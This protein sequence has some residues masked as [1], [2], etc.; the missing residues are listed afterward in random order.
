MTIEVVLAYGQAALLTTL[1]VAGPL[2]LSSLIVGTT[3]SVLQA[4]TQVQEVTLV[5]VPKIVAAF[6]V[7]A[8]AG[9]WMLQ[10]AVGFGTQMFLSIPQAGP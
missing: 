5:F 9:G 8:V 10:I 6:L 7:V 1:S 3:I 4:V 2:L